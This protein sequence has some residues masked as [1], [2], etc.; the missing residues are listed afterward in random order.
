MMEPPEPM[1]RVMESLDRLEKGEGI[2]MQHRMKPRLL[3]PKLQEWGFEFEVLK[4]APDQVE[5]RIWL[6][7]K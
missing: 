4:H 7:S 3:S 6:E 2:Q 1:L 5:V